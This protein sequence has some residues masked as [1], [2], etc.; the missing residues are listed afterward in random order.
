MV[1][2]R[3]CPNIYEANDTPEGRTPCPACGSIARVIN[4]AAGNHLSL[5]QMLATK[6]RSP[7]QK[8][9]LEMKSGHEYFRLT[10]V[11]TQLDRVI[12]KRN[13]WYFEHIT[14]L[15]TGEVRKHCEEP[16]NQH[17]GHGSAKNG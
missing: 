2:C 5:H 3:N 11:W 7:G 9:N 12:D 17:R 15:E 6:A 4:A 16:L 1:R 14:D 13:N 8:A 10:G